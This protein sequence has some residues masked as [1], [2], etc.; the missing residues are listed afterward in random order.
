MEVNG[1][2]RKR[3]YGID[4]RLKLEEGDKVKISPLGRKMVLKNSGIEI[5]PWE[6]W[7]VEKIQFDITQGRR[8]KFMSTISMAGYNTLWMPISDLIFYSR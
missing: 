3:R 6:I 4:G 2:M 8:G 5:E 1:K 7:T